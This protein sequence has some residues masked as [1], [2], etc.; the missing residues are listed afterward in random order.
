MNVALTPFRPG[1][2]SPEFPGI[3]NL[4]GRLTSDRCVTQTHP[5]PPSP[6]G[7]MRAPRQGEDRS[8]PS[9]LGAGWR[10]AEHGRPVGSFPGAPFPNSYIQVR[11]T[12]QVQRQGHLVTLPP[13]RPGSGSSSGGPF[14]EYP[15]GPTPVQARVGGRSDTGK[16]DTAWRPWD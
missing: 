11:P 2:P 14:N 16:R 12:Y 15:N 6:A 9:L 4:Q 5:A 1:H 13:H 7:C 10:R 3:G 8:C